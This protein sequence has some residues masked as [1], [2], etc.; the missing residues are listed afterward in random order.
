MRETIEERPSKKLIYVTSGVRD[1]TRR[2]LLVLGRH[3]KTSNAPLEVFEI[4]TYFIVD[5]PLAW[6]ETLLD[7]L[8]ERNGAFDQLHGLFPASPQFL[9]P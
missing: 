8:K 6:F 5:A 2:T 9:H 1:E 7:V 4:L 3:S